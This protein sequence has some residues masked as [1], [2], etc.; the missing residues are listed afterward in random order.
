MAHHPR[1]PAMSKHV[2]QDVGKYHARE[3]LWPRQARSE[4]TR[5]LRGSNILFLVAAVVL[6]PILLMMLITH[7]VALELFRRSKRRLKQRR[8]TGARRD[9][10][11]V[12]VEPAPFH[13]RLEVRS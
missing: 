9:N 13:S 10:E 2:D 6:G 1:L 3:R 7:G 8:E 12:A 11:V 4:A 5:P